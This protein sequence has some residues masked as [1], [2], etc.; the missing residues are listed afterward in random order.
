M[1][2]VVIVSVKLP[3]ELLRE[4]DKL[5]EQGFFSSRSE[6][7][8]RGIALLIKNYNTIYDRES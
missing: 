3:K 5:V 1:R 2:K 4:I 6:A 8:R 7:I